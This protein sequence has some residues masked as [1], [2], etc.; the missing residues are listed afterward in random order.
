M[1]RI[2][3]IL[4]ENNKERFKKSLE[5]LEKCDIAFFTEIVKEG[6]G[7]GF[8]ES[9]ISVGVSNLVFVLSIYEEDLERA[10]I[11]LEENG[12][13]LSKEMFKYEEDEMDEEHLSAFSD[14]ID[15]SLN[16]DSDE[17]NE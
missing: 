17:K 4:F 14:P 16:I 6:E 8:N 12:I 11:E 13:K 9:I 5:I 1:G 2:V 3:E 10:I 15:T 7:L